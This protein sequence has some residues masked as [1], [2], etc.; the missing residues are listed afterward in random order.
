MKANAKALL[1]GLAVAISTAIPLVD[2][3]LLFSEA[4]T[5]IGAALAAGVVVWRVPNV[6]SEPT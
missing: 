6:V 5:I 4:L 1:A 2:D 3:G